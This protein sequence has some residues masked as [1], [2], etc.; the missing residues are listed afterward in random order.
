MD[1][2]MVRSRVSCANLTTQ[3][4]FFFV[5]RTLDDCQPSVISLHKLLVRERAGQDARALYLISSN[6]EEPEMFEFICVS[7]KDKAFWLD[8][9]RKAI[10]TCPAETDDSQ[11]KGSFAII[12]AAVVAW[13]LLLPGH[14]LQRQSYKHF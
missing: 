11:E 7:P 9:I 12:F 2:L 3:S 6:P 4:A 10:E 5:G 13:K 1:G 8:A 14:G